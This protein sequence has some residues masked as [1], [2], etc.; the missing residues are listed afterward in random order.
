MGAPLFSPCEVRRMPVVSAFV[1][2][3]GVRL[4][5]LTEPEPNN[6]NLIPCPN[7]TCQRQ[8][9]VSGRV[10]SVFVVAEDGIGITPYDWTKRKT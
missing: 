3:C 8:R 7:P 5:V 1:C 6:T 10:L 2:E 9:V 4:N